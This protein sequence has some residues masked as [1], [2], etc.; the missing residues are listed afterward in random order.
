MPTGSSSGF[1]S[2]PVTENSNPLASSHRPMLK[3]HGKRRITH[4][5][6]V[7]AQLAELAASHITQYKDG[8]WREPTKFISGSY[9]LAYV[10]FEALRRQRN[11]WNRSGKS[12][13]LISI[14]DL[15]E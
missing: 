13:I 9:S 6:P 11:A 4:T 3:G 2:T 7:P 14:I 15:A 10:L 5:T 8:T 12:E 1:I